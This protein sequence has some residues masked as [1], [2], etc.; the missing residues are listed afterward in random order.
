MFVWTPPPS[1]ARRAGR[2]LE[3]NG[4]DLSWTS[5]LRT[6]KTPRRG[7]I[8]HQPLLVE[9]GERLAQRR[10]ADAELF[11]QLAL[12]ETKLGA[13]IVDVHRLDGGF[14]RFI[15]ARIEAEALRQRL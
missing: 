2:T 8:L 12:I 1:V 15:N 10:S 14:E 6:M 11:G 13:V 7:T 3:N 4:S 9:A 5:I